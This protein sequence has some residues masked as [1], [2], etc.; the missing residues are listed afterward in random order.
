MDAVPAYCSLSLYRPQ[1]V[2]QIAARKV[3]MSPQISA[4]TPKQI[5][6]NTQKHLWNSELFLENRF[7][8]LEKFQALSLCII[9]EIRKFRALFLYI[10]SESEKHRAKQGV[11]RHSTTHLRDLKPN[12]KFPQISIQVFDMFHVLCP[13][14]D[15]RVHPPPP[16]LMTSH[17]G[18]P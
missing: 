12:P 14:Q 1:F 17:S 3:F 5:A 9:S 8:H 2:F 11:G 7:R 16:P 4:N 13:A 6:A 15:L 10:G 18:I